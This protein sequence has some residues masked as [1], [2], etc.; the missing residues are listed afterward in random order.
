[1]ALGSAMGIPVDAFFHAINADLDAARKLLGRKRPRLSTEQRL[2]R[3][4]LA[5]KLCGTLRELIRW[6]ITPENCIRWLKRFQERQANG[7]NTPPAKKPGRPW[8]K[9]EKVEAIL[10]IYDAGCTGLS[11]IVGEMGKCG[12]TVAESTVRR[13]LTA[14]GRPPT[15][16]NHRR[17]STWGQFWNRHAK[18]MVGV[19]FIQIPIGF[20][21]KIVNAFVFVA[22]EHDTRR[23]HLLGI[24]THP[25]D[26]WIANRLR[27][28][29]MLG[30]PLAE[31]KFWI[32]DNDGKYGKQT[33]DI[34]GK[35]LVWTSVEAPD[36][37]A[38][39]ER[40]NKSIQDVST[41]SS[42]CRRNISGNSSK[43]TSIIITLNVRTKA[44]A[45]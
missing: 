14:H 44:S 9:P 33:I 6:I 27:N 40:W 31:R 28:A 37:N 42:S 10:R 45:M 25:T 22:I 12:H 43:R 35:M 36:M 17:G 7:G 26:A 39:I 20:L 5:Q 4:T 18:F 41:M 19:D 1:M 15:D 30:G 34:L 23:V 16:H 13:V 24:T 8:I 21:G 32:L 38:I 29:T 3:A 11:R 2:S